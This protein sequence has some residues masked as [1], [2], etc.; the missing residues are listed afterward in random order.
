[1]TTRVLLHGKSVSFGP[2]LRLALERDGDIEVLDARDPD[3]SS[4]A[5]LLLVDLDLAHEE[6]VS[7]IEHLMSTRPLPIAIVT[8][9]PDGV[10]TAALAA[11]ALDTFGRRELDVSLPDGVVAAALRRRVKL[12]ARVHVIHHPRANIRKRRAVDAV[13]GLDRGARTT[14][15][16]IAASTGGPQAL[17]TII[18]ALPATF[19]PPLLVVQHLSPGFT[20]GL[21]RWLSK[22]VALPVRIAADGDRPSG[23]VW[24]APDDAHLVLEADGR[25]GLDRATPATPHRPAADVLFR[26]VAM[27]AG[28]GAA[29]VVLTGMGDDGAKGTA[30]VKAAGGVTIA[31]DKESSAIYGMPRAAADLGAENILPLESIGPA[32]A[33][34]TGARR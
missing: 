4:T 8:D 13:V 9:A 6:G 10:A 7:L 16:A 27:N 22:E 30:E 3:A 32:L 15:V 14:V 12:L 2:S 31:Q 25:L 28:A 1:M 23:G 5:D 26:S 24:L 19:H 21:L 11:G 34:L 29:V 18:R 20:E 33:A 17:L